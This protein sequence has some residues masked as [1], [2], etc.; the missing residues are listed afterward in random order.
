MSKI[1]FICCHL[2]IDPLLSILYNIL[3]KNNVNISL[4]FIFSPNFPNRILST[5]FVLKLFQL[6]N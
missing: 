2:T 5:N 4:N 1:L 3:G 6:L